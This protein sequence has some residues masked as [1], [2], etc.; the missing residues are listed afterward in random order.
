MRIGDLVK[1]KRQSSY[2]IGVVTR[3]YTFNWP[4][5]RTKAFFSKWGD[6]TFRTIDLEVIN[7]SR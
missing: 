3:V 4:D 1:H 2:G 7:E 6:C 5:D